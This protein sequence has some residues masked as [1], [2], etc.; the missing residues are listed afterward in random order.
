ME[1]QLRIETAKAQ[2]ELM[3]SGMSPPKADLRFAVKG[4]ADCTR[5]TGLASGPFAIDH[6]KGAALAECPLLGLSGRGQYATPLNLVENDPYAT[7][8]MPRCHNDSQPCTKAIDNIAASFPARPP[9]NLR[10]A[11]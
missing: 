9:A 8:K 2:D 1:G 3:I 4:L 6:D 11:S 10:K 7:F 5:G